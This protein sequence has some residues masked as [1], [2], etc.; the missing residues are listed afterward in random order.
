MLSLN[1]TVNTYQLTSLVDTGSTLSI[2]HK[3]FIYLIPNII[4]NKC[5][6]PILK[7]AN[8]SAMVP[9]GKTS[10]S[11]E[12]DGQRLV[13]EMYI[14]DSVP[15]DALLGLDFLLLSKMKIDFGEFNSSNS[16][17]LS[18]MPFFS[19]EFKFKTKTNIRV[20]QDTIV[21]KRSGVI[22]DLCNSQ[23]NE[24]LI[25]FKP[26]EK[27]LSN[28]NLIAYE[29]IT[30]INNFQLF[31][32]IY[33]FNN[34]NI[35]LRKNTC[36]GYAQK[37]EVN[38]E[39]STKNTHY[40]YN[41]I[42][43]SEFD[44]SFVN[45]DNIFHEKISNVF[46]E[47]PN[48]NF[49]K[50][51]SGSESI[52]HSFDE[53]SEKQIKHNISD[54]LNA[55]Q[56][57]VINDLLIKFREIFALNIKELT[58]T[59][60]TAHKI[61]TLTEEPVYRPPYRASKLEKMAI[62]EQVH[63]MLEAG[64]ITESNSTYASPVVMV[65]KPNGKYRFCVD[66]RWL[67]AITKRDPYPLPLIQDLMTAFNGSQYFT[68]LDFTGAYWQVPLTDD[69]KPKSAFVTQEGHYQFEVLPFGLSS[70]PLTFQ[71][72][73][74][75]LIAGLKYNTCVAYIDDLIIYAEKFHEHISRIHEIFI[76]VREGNLKLSPDKC[77]FC[78]PEIK[79]LGWVVNKDGTKPNTEKVRAITEFPRPTSKKNVKSFLGVCSYYRQSINNF[80]AIAEPLIRLL[81]K[82]TEFFWSESVNIA[83]ERLKQALVTAPVLVHYDYNKKI[84]LETDASLEGLGYVL[85]HEI[86]GQNHPFHFGSRTLKESE[87]KYSANQLEATCIAWAILKSRNYLLGVKFEVI[88]DACSLCYVMRSRSNKPYLDRLVSRLVEFEFDIVYRSG[89]KHAHV[90]A[91]SR[92]PISDDSDDVRMIDMELPSYNLEIH[93]IEKLQQEDDWCKRLGDQLGDS[94]EIMR[95]EGKNYQKV[96]GVVYRVIDT[97]SDTLYQMLVPQC[98]RKEIL[99][100]MHEE[101]LSGHLGLFKT[102]KKMRDRFHWPKMYKSID[103]FIAK[104]PDC[105]ARKPP[106]GKP[107]GLGQIM[108]T[109]IV[110]FHTIACDIFGPLPETVDVNKYIVVCVDLS[111]RYVIASAL[112]NIK[113]QTIVNFLINNVVLVFGAP[114]FLLTDQGKQFTSALT[115][116]FLHKLDTLHLRTSAYHPCTNG[117]VESHNKTLA[118]MLYMFTNDKQDNWDTIL[119]YVVFAYN[120]SVHQSTKFSPFKLLFGHEPRLPIDNILNTPISSIFI[121]SFGEKL[122]EARNLSHLF[123]HETQLR[124]KEAHDERSIEGNFKLNDEVM[125]FTPSRKK[126]KSPKLSA[127]YYGPF[128]II[129][130]RSPVNVRVRNDRA[131]REEIV[132]V[133]R[134]KKY[135]NELDES[136]GEYPEL[137]TI[138]EDPDEDE[139][140]INRSISRVNL[141]NVSDE[142]VIEKSPVKLSKFGR[143]LKAVKRYGFDD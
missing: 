92:N 25:F 51:L 63:E 38:P 27:Y 86:D 79:F 23:L 133:S 127:K 134:L 3:K 85:N 48:E 41:L 2:L 131:N 30:V 93:E 90:D 54:T 99:Q 114:K 50:K 115:Q 125:V 110:P 45:T 95:I 112:S 100:T 6:T 97:S 55:E 62:N 119:P 18:E 118:N 44:N 84:K 126:G 89:T 105:A 64:I 22:V 9:Y 8:G 42:E 107:L 68:T 69:S 74:D 5:T 136:L 34:H 78:K 29:G 46:D 10:A 141:V 53:T 83:F 96:D 35:K 67:N 104:C 12:Y 11:V 140:E 108:D 61:D 143:I 121:Q 137:S 117:I 26:K 31:Y 1:C 7:L 124:N 135:R 43:N 59:N 40:N 72:M 128:K 111:T 94:A 66:Y 32:L 17:N 14:Y 21:P 103:K 120:T 109:P 71:R 82:N 65:K 75:K 58:K 37:V 56:R 98:L 116:E 129:E 4:V 91:L 39:T 52:S 80:S 60:L 130:I 49:I 70:A 28:F 15:F 113:A 76:R 142:N 123:G 101:P 47:N 73:I 122:M 20:A 77:H 106:S 36:V 13:I 33:N 102:F 57:Q 19:H 138:V 87:E 24:K 88:T 16:C 81:R 132:H 139:S